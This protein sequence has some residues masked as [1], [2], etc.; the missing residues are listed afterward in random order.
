MLSGAELET[1]FVGK[2]QLKGFDIDGMCTNLLEQF[3]ETREKYAPFT[4][5]F[6]NAL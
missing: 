2:Y 5:S 6:L 3:C 4:N 1:S